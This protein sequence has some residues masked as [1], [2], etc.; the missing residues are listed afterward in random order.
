MGAGSLEPPLSDPPPSLPGP[1]L[2]HHGQRVA[3]SG[4]GLILLGKAIHQTD[5]Q[6]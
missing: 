1:P 5:N 6:M 4:P 2:P 3:P